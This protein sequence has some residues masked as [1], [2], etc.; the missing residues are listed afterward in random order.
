VAGPTD[1]CPD[2]LF[3]F[4]IRLPC[5]EVSLFAKDGSQNS[6]A[7]G[8]SIAMPAETTFF[9]RDIWSPATLHQLPKAASKGAA[10]D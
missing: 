9:D 7:N 4:N 8:M 2:I 10:K 5:C 3:G 6:H 1:D